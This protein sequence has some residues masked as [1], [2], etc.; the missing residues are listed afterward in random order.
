MEPRPGEWPAYHRDI[1]DFASILE[2][3]QRGD[4]EAVAVLWRH[5]NHRLLRYFRAR[6]GDEAEDLA[7]ETWIAAARGLPTFAG[8][9]DAFRAWLF[10]IGRRRL[11]DWQ[12]RE[13]RRP[14]AGAGDEVL[15]ARP[16]LDDTAGAALDDLDTAAALA[17]V[18]SLA[19]DQAEVILLRVLAGLD[20]ARVAE[21]LGKRPGAVRVLQH[22]GLRR[23]RELTT[24]ESAPRSV[25]R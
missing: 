8:D 25:T 14:R 1:D 17:L 2:R 5:L 21:V 11:I 16:A 4:G 15:V 12:R 13:Q 19:P 7:S 20:V 10:T 3:A 18:G 22:R 6:V 9:E 24:T 23:L